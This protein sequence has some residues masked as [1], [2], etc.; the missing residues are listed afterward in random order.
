MSKHQRTHNAA[1][2]RLLDTMDDEKKE[3]VRTL[4]DAYAETNFQNLRDIKTVFS[5]PAFTEMGYTPL[6]IIKDYFGSK[7]KYF[8]FLCE[9]E[10][11]LYE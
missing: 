10:N 11:K 8:L 3:I 9:L 7:D 6:K 5:M 1:I 4:L 2:A